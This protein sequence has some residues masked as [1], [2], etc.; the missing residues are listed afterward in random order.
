MAAR[1]ER[2]H[3]N[4]LGLGAWLAVLTSSVPVSATELPVPC[5]GGSCMPQGATAPGWVQS[6]AASLA[7]SGARMTVNQASTS[8]LLNW[9]KFNISAD[10][11]VRF[12]QPGSGSVAVN[13]V[14]DPS[15][16]PSQI[17]GS[18][19]ANGQV[20]ILNRNGILFGAGSQVN[21]GGLV[22]SSLD[23]SPGARANGIA[24]AINAGAPA[25]Q[26]FATIPGATPGDGAVTV[27]AGATI[28]ANGGQV[29]LFS[30]TK[31]ENDGVIQT[32][33]GQTI[34][35]AG[36]RVFLAASADP[37]LRGLL[38]QV[39]PNGTVN[40]GSP[41]G[42]AAAAADVAQIIADR[43]NVT[44]AASAVNQYGRVS[45]TTTARVNGSIVLRA[46]SASVLTQTK[47]VGLP[48]P[49]PDA[50]GALTLGP[51]STTAVSL[52]VDPGDKTVDA[53]AQPRSAISLAGGAVE[54][55]DHASIAAPGGNVT[56]SA[57]G[58]PTLGLPDQ[59]DGARIWLAPTSVIDVSGAS[60]ALP[61][62]RNSLAVQ[63]RASELADFPVQRD[64]PLHGDTVY[65]DVRQY[66]TRADGSQWVGS[67]IADLSGDLSTIQR[68]VLERNLTGG[69]ISLTSSG[70]VLVPQGA[71]LNVSGGQID[72]Q[73]GYLKT[74]VLFGADGKTYPI[75][76]ADPNRSYVG[77]ADALTITNAR[78]GVTTTYAMPG[79][80]QNGTYVQGYVQG[81]S[82]GTVAI[83][84]PALVLDG[85]ILGTTARGPLQRIPSLSP[86]QADQIPLG[87]Q[88]VLGN[89]P[90]TN[91]S[92]SE[93]LHSLQFQSGEVLGTLTAD[94]GQPFNPLT[95]SLPTDFVSSLRPDILGPGSGVTRLS[96]YAV[97]Q[98]ALPS[99]VKLAPGAGGV[100][101]LEAGQV[102]VDGTLDV[103]AGAIALKS[104]PTKI[105]DGSSEEALPGVFVGSQAQLLATG[106]WVN[107]L[108]TVTAA[109]TAPLFT[110][111]GSI[112][113]QSI[114]GSLVFQQ[115]ALLDVS[116]GAQLIS[117]GRV[118]AGSGGTL[119]IKSQPGVAALSAAAI[120]QTIFAP[121]LRGYAMTAGGSLSLALPTVCLSSSPCE[122]TDATQLD[123]SVLTDYGF[124]KVSI[125]ATA[126]G[127]TVASDVN[128]AVR[129]ENLVLLPS[130]RSAPTGTAF[131]ALTQL[132]LLPDYARQ[133]ENLTLSATA[134]ASGATLAG[135]SDLT[136]GQGAVLNFDALAAVALTSDS[137]IFQNGVLR[138]AGGSVS[139]EVNNYPGSLP[140]YYADQG[141]WLGS[142][143]VID[144]SGTARLTPNNLGL[145]LGQVLA[146]GSI[147]ISATH[148]FLTSLP[149]SLLEAAGSSGTLDVQVGKSAASPY[150]RQSVASPGGSIS[151][152]AAEG[153][154]LSGTLDGKTG[155]AGASGGSLSIGLLAP[156]RD[157]SFMAPDSPRQLEIA[158]SGPT[159]VL[160]EGAAAPASVAGT[161]RIL[162]SLINTGGFDQID[163]S[164]RNYTV[165][166]SSGSGGG[167][168]GAT[169]TY[170]G[171]VL[172][173]SGVDL[174]PA[175][176]LRVDAPTIEARGSG[177]VHL[178]SAY[179]ALGSSDTGEQSID[180][181]PAAG[182]ATLQVQGQLLDLIGDF[183]LA[184]FGDARLSSSGDI[185]AIGVIIPASSQGAPLPVLAQGSLTTAGNLTLQ[186]Q[187][188]YPATLTSYTIDLVGATPERSSLRVTGAPGTPDLVLSAGGSLTLRASSIVNSGVIRAP[189]GSLTLDAPS[190]SLLPGSLLS[191]S[192]Q[193]AT[194]PF[195]TTQAGLDWVYEI[196]PGLDFVYGSAAGDLPPPQ[197]SIT[198]TA[199]QVDFR[200]GATID[201]SGGGDLQADEFVSGPQG[202][203]DLLSAVQDPGLFAVLPG[204]SLPFAPVDPFADR[205]FT[206]NPGSSVYL[207][208]G[209][210]LPA[211]TY[212]LLPARYALLPGAFLVRP[213]SGYAD[214]TPGLQIGQ[215]DGT[216]V[217]SGRRVYAGTDLGDALT[218]GFDIAP[219]SYILKQAQYTTT[220]AN[221]FFPG[222][223]AAAD[224]AS[225]RVPQDAGTLSISASSAINLSGTLSAAAASGGRGSAVDLSADDLVVTDSPASLSV[226]Q[227]AIDPVQLDALGAESIL[228]GGTRTANADGSIAV[229]VV[230]NDVT[231][232]SGAVLHAPEL[233]IAAT[234]QIAVQ[235]GAQLAASGTAVSASAPLEATPGSAFLRV[236]TGPQADL[237]FGTTGSAPGS[238][239]GAIS[240]AA[241]AS[242]ASSGSL[243]VD[244]A[245]VS[246]AGALN[247]TG[248]A[249]RLDSS[250]LGLGAVPDAFQ[251]FGIST[252]LLAG[253]TGTQ[254]Q[255]RTAQ[256]IQVYGAVSLSLASLTLEAPG[257]TA[258]SGD[259]TLGVTAQQVTFT[260]T[261]S[262]A[263]AP[264]AAPGGGGMSFTA[265]SVSLDKGT[266]V[267]GGVSSASISA[268]QDVSLAGDGQ[269]SS[270]GDVSVNAGIFQSTGAYN[271]T[272]ASTG[273]ITT[274]SSQ[275][276]A[277]TAMAAPGGALTLAGSNISLGGNF[278]LPAGQLAALATGSV[279]VADG[280]VVN[281]AGQTKV[282]DGESVSTSGGAFNLAASAGSISI[283]PSALI[284]VSGGGPGAQ[285]GSI[286]LIASQGL[287]DFS[288]VIHGSAAAGAAGAS[289][290][291]DA[292]SLNF[293]QLLAQGE[294]GGLTGDWNVRLRG[295]GD[296]SIDSGRLLR[297]SDV[298][299][300]ADQGSINIGGTIDASG[301]NGGSITLAAA[302]R[303]EIEGTLTAAATERTDRGGAITLESNG[304]QAGDGLFVDAGALLNVGG[305]A[306]GA[307]PG[308]VYLRESADL[309]QTLPGSDPASAPLRLDGTIH[310]AGQT[311]LEAF[312]VY[313]AAS[314]GDAGDSGNQ[315]NNTYYTDAANFMTG[316]AGVIAQS[317]HRSG[318]PSFQI[319]PGVEIQSDG[320][321]HIAAT[322]DLSGWRFGDNFD[323]PGVLTLRA[324]GNLYVD[325][326]LSDGFAFD[327]TDRTSQSILA[328]P[329]GP[330]W[331][332]RLVAGADL[333]SANPMGLAAQSAV[334]PTGGSL[335]VAAGRP[336]TPGT[337]NGPV[338][339]RT[340]TGSIQIA[341]AQDVVLKNQ[342]SAIYTGGEEAPGYVIT[343][344]AF[345]GGLSGL[346]YP[347]NGGSISVFAGRDVLGAPSSQLFTD[348]LWRTG[349]T[350]PGGD[351]T[352]WTI[353][354]D[355]FEQGIGAL[356]GGDLTVR[357]GGNIVDLGAVVPSAGIPATATSVPTEVNRGLLT[358]EAGGDIAGGKFLAMAGS[359]T[360]RA[361]GGVVAG[362]PQ[363]SADID[364]YPV[365]ALGDA[366]LEVSARRTVTIGTVVDPTLLPFS[367]LQGRPDLSVYFSTYTDRSSVDIN[368]AGG[369]VSLANDVGAL[370]QTSTYLGFTETTVPLYAYPPS[371]R[372]VA[373]GGDIQ[374]QNGMD[375][376]PAAHGNLDLL[377][378]GSV[379]FAQ[380]GAVAGSLNF[381]NI[382]VSDADP[383]LL[384]SVTTP[385]G[386]GPF[387]TV[388]DQ[389]NQ[390]QAGVHAPHPVHGGFYAA[391]S[392]P[393]TVPARIVALTG[394]IALEPNSP[395]QSSALYISKPIDIIAGRDIID[396][397]LLD[398]QFAADNV[399]TVSAGRD[400]LETSGR[401]LS[402]QL[403]PNQ[404]TIEVDGPGYL[405]VQAGR[406]INLGTSGGIVSGGNLHNTALPSG[407]ATLS[408]IAG[409]D[410][411]ATYPAFIQTYLADD[412]TYDGDLIAFMETLS[413]QTL[414]DKAAALSLFEALAPQLQTPLIETILFGEL[415][416]G[417]RAAAQPGPT[418][419][420]FR[421][422]DAA[423]TALF[424]GS[425]PD[426]AAG[427][428]N[429]YLG[430]LNLYFSRIYTLA[431][432]DINLVAPGGEINVG[433]ATAPAAFGVTKSPDLLGVVARTSG[434]VSALAYGDT[435]VNQSRIF[436]ADGGNIL[437]WS[438]EG[439]IDAG[440]GAKTAISAP[441]P[442]ITIDP[443]TGQPTLVYPPALQ[444]SGIQTLATSPGTVPGDVDLFA[445]HGV[446]NANDAGIVAGNLT[447]AATAV[448]GTNNISVSGTSVGVPVEVTGLGVNFAAAASSSA[449]ATSSADTS[450]A[451]SR[452]NGSK[453]PIASS[454][455]SWLE[456]FVLG[457]G[458]EQCQTSDVECLKRQKTTN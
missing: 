62:E 320:D 388:L 329:A 354:F 453:A 55:L 155:G 411:T 381:E 45:A 159:T 138:S 78:W 262:S 189:I 440:R 246:Y 102:H 276:V 322:W 227:V 286:E 389:L 319:L 88:L 195:G 204:I 360:I 143:S 205:G 17:L 8:A 63:L 200:Q 86:T 222:Q 67:P 362:S 37:N 292:Q 144:V 59:P 409:V 127:L 365:L 247:A 4:V 250:Q 283:A 112:D 115:G 441:P 252:E 258:A 141:I 313:D 280:T 256:P 96:A 12:N 317:L 394:D 60:E 267:L 215:L 326:T 175:V 297:G 335:I 91:G 327:A 216:V 302:H 261:C 13:Q 84:A 284:D 207:S 410:S 364:L 294:A 214:L 28:N 5:A 303:V 272:I 124:G 79:V 171:S 404:R 42:S 361:G 69:T 158:A 16:R 183:D 41:D 429:P 403:Q 386:A 72:W 380:P 137:R 241:G 212:A 451:D 444:G 266:F 370:T 209:D 455:M 368:S 312:R 136:I 130:A 402:G 239:G 340:G 377:A 263:C 387:G 129:Q 293:S 430:D 193:G 162:A 48:P 53:N 257:L 165:T 104:L 56:I 15:A 299:L 228:L 71:T 128:T 202:T 392:Q 458:E 345:G 251:G 31:V 172:F 135:Y 99:G 106:G 426:L 142:S 109:P 149:G 323:I 140:L 173:D 265:A 98:I 75:A 157:S 11:S 179:V 296:L 74:S 285:G 125:G 87:A 230:S 433:L 35:G 169:T 164:S 366:Q 90:G 270:S 51:G 412:S 26:K 372:A 443:T 182:A 116:G 19:S 344:P 211:G 417:G 177:T 225:A 321:L 229:Q 95:D 454:A 23:M 187:Q 160:A 234:Q 18:L 206:L 65:V 295:P 287:V 154:L 76:E 20:Y 420:D 57:V 44:L 166:Q 341:A 185:R 118:V 192:A 428:K 264:V 349:S 103:P 29:M 383:A 315:S 281:L 131:S 194:I 406:D 439:D 1:G 337:V 83:T 413:G 343:A 457:L 203:R 145:L 39:G 311:T 178:E 34:L 70:S 421:R 248:A 139:L 424:P 363:G 308:T 188:V 52:E 25:F 101:S 168:G 414:L 259:T 445:P 82:A 425:N 330:S 306:G 92:S 24:Q 32:P 113:V 399:S 334:P 427:E 332:Y 100:V 54:V 64:G 338:V 405:T 384:P 111:G 282:F 350:I 301:P 254:L 353:S 273:N 456:V 342:A 416:A 447:I 357:A 196:S 224:I 376:W 401:T 132:A 375:L 108:P 274:T 197:K 374:V 432:G 452:S 369:G 318:D 435:Q 328:D 68:D 407:G 395:N 153:L 167:G 371:L 333:S 123:P 231:V 146:G 107:D 163:L 314:V 33:D 309:L 260:G 255:L 240:V 198:I 191:V 36:D 89:L 450:A 46:Q 418:H 219:G 448:L 275:V 156:P 397:G 120:P 290:T 10:G 356:G 151:L 180:A 316:Y 279:H 61:M 38:I 324:A 199:S 446:V 218:S 49:P 3:S 373:F 393:D 271:Y 391:D 226:G 245:T 47:G 21:V 223:A 253:L 278:S 351:P 390:F 367:N 181:S 268:Q 121:T 73:S 27:E 288:G 9:Q 449:A 122:N 80:S 186:A 217:V 355:N 210:G 436:A 442:T 190:V 431:G 242:L 422:A 93:V 213:V 438:T 133:P 307:T 415:R 117:S 249:V 385:T 382:I 30:P 289:L 346:A 348:W 347:V 105:F 379:W 237:Q 58:N 110:S 331:S 40:N 152:S 77:T 233:L 396:L 50:S 352:A 150:V 176:A 220:S 184:G 161:G 119:S 277:P 208:G 359:G 235:A 174:A 437:I 243:S 170:R 408:V 300:T 419:N 398:Q 126:F 423:L 6:G 298:E 310:G 2:I 114:Q 43:G 325:H 244:A 7:Q 232:D 336:S 147:G 81:A 304:S 94:D 22:A 97:D 434:S 221:S 378:N 305:A 358:V 291:V 85:S 236:S 238:A 66:G 269:L 148:G 14:F 339:V 400:I 134:A 201:L